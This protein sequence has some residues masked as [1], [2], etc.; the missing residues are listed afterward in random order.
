MAY[1]GKQT[2]HRFVGATV[3]GVL[4]PIIVVSVTPED[5]DD[6]QTFTGRLDRDGNTVRPARL[7]LRFAADKLRRAELSPSIRALA[8]RNYV[9]FV[10]GGWDETSGFLHRLRFVH[11]RA[12]EVLSVRAVAIR[13]RTVPGAEHPD[14]STARLDRNGDSVIPGT[15]Y[16]RYAADSQRWA[17][18]NQAPG[19]QAQR[20][21]H[22][23]TPEAGRLGHRH[24]FRVSVLRAGEMMTAR[25]VVVD[26]Q[27]KTSGLT[28]IQG[29]E[30]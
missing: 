3:L 23:W 21:V 2:G 19:E 8:D 5:P 16:L 14:E 27:R 26:V 10:L 18:L 12:G 7:W 22:A 28:R 17:D 29:E 9:R 20:F 11:L 4:R 6:T 24:R 1:G 25:R 13:A 30:T 15:G